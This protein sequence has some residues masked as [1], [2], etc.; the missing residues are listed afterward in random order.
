MPDTSA[1]IVIS[2]GGP[3][4]L[5]AAAGF[6]HAGFSVLLVDPNT[7][8]TQADAPRADMRSTAF[9]RPA[10]DLFEQTGLWPSLAPHAVPL[11][12]LRIVDTAGEPPE[13]RDERVFHPDT[14]EEN[15]PLGWNFLN[16]EIRRI[17]L[18]HLESQPNIDLRF[19]TAYRTHLA[20]SH[21]ALVHLS[22]GTRV[23]T[24]LLIG[25]D[26]RNSPVRESAGIG[27]RITRY[28]QKSLAFTATHALAHQNVSTEIYHRGGPF[29]MVPL[30]AIDGRPASA[31]VWM[32]PGPRALELLELEPAAFNEEMV[33]RSAG[34]FGA[35][36]L[37]SARTAFPIVS[38]QARHLVA[39]RCAII[40][41]AAHVLPPIGAQGLN[42]SLNDVAALL[43]AARAAP[44]QLGKPQMLSRY[45]HN[46]KKDIA[47][48]ARVIDIFNR[49]TRSGAAPL[50]AM[51]LAGLKAAHDI[52]PLRHA[53]MRA[54]MGPGQRAPR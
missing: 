16:W 2:G 27:T 32:N 3:A 4:G 8:V 22:D 19:G 33:R 38:M 17:L 34:L 35:M 51:R 21:E 15:A 23:R 1:D 20:R 7:P 28:G 37:A 42:T 45:A 12:A 10:R 52:T 54:G 44:D 39:E 36:E 25:A 40:A 26:G 47:R 53:L 48:R 31:I 29:T 43:D 49:I 11:E 9:L 46:R 6:G 5:I 24:R 50:Q 18:Q 41:E 14:A 30:Q 13:I